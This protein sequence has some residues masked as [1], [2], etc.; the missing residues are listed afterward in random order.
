MEE[1]QLSTEV[2]SNYKTKVLLIGGVVGL[3][4]GLGAAYMLI[5]RAERDQAEPVL[6]LGEGVKLGL[7]VFGLLRQVAQLGEGK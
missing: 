3:L 4:A 6:N 2:N 7:L 1:T 5:Q